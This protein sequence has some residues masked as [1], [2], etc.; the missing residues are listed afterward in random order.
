M[1]PVPGI[2]LVAPP[3]VR[4]PNF[5]R[6][7]VLLCE[8]GESGSFG[9]VLNRPLSVDLSDILDG[10][11]GDG[12]VSMGGPVQKDTLHYLHR[13]GDMVEDAA[14]V[15][16][17][18][19]WGGDFAAVRILVDTQITSQHSLRFFLGYAGWSAGQLES[20]IEA[21]GWFLTQ[22]KPAFVFHSDPKSLWRDVLRHMGGEYA[23]LVNFP[24]HPRVN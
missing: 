23:L 21:G 15:T 20:E 5:A 18:V 8:H 17:G 24:D 22:A 14:E 19:Y 12:L 16:D 9:L 6:T 1:N 13:H 4:D 11:Q 10:L 7:V 3:M 2:L